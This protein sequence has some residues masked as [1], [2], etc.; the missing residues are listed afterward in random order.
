MIN[1]EYA[2]KLIEH[3]KEAEKNDKSAI[4]NFIKHREIR[5]I[6][7]FTHIDNL[8]SILDF[9]LQSRINLNLSNIKPMFS[10]SSRSEGIPQGIF[11]SI[12]YP[13]IWMLEQKIHSE[14]DVF[15]VLEIGE[16]SLLDREF[17]AFPGN[18]ATSF[19]RTDAT[20]NPYEYVGVSGLKN[21]FLNDELRK[22]EHIPRHVPTDLQ[23]EIIFFD[24]LEKER[25]R[26]VHFSKLIPNN[27]QYIFEILSND[28]KHLKIDFNCNHEYFQRQTP[29]RKHD[30]RKFNLDWKIK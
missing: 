14:G 27:L 5:N 16:N 7:H 3:A 22:K 17:A 2:N 30:G 9:G 10:D 1:P 11:C 29:S 25:I 24:S 26:R 4:V 8:T 15:A 6:L 19:I 28:Y 13:N 12:A 20:Q 21:M 18:S 23:S